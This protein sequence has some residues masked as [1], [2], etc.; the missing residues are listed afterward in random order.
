MDA[1]A[2]PL[3]LQWMFKFGA[4]PARTST[5]GSA[6]EQA[7]ELLF[8][9]VEVNGELL[10]GIFELEIAADGAMFLAQEAWA[11]ARLRPP[12]SSHRLRQGTTGFALAG[13][14]GGTYRIDRRQMRLEIEAPVAALLSSTLDLGVVQPAPAGG[15]PD[16]GVMLNYDLSATYGAAGV[17]TPGGIVELVSFSRYGKFVTSAVGAATDGRYRI[18]RLDTYWRYDIPGRMESLVIGDTVGSGG[19]WS[20]PA[21]YSGVQFARNFGLRAGFVTLPTLTLSGQAGLPSTVDV[22]V[23][24]ISRARQSVPAGPFEVPNVPLTAGAGRLNL[25]VRDL[26]GRETLVQ[27]SYYASNSL[28]APGLKDYSLEAGWLRTGYGASSE[29]GDPFTAGTLRAGISSVLTGE[30]RFELQEGRYAAGVQLAYVFGNWG[31]GRAALAVARSNLHGGSE[32]GLLYQFGAERMSSDTGVSLQYEGAT[33][34]F[35]PFAEFRDAESALQRTRQQWLAIASTRIGGIWGSGTYLHHTRWDGQR[36]ESVGAVLT[37]PV[38]RAAS[39]SANLSKRIDR[40]GGWTASVQLAVPLESGVFLGARTDRFAEGA[41][42]LTIFANSPMP[43]GAG[44]SWNVEASTHAHRLARG[45][46]R[47]HG[48]VAELALDAVSDRD[49]HVAARVDARGTVGMVGRVPFA[50]RPV[51]EGSVG[52]VQVPGMPDVPVRYRNQVI[53]TTNS[54]GMIIVPALLPWQENR[55]EIDPADLPLDVELAATAKTITPHARA[56][57]LI[58]FDVQRSISLL[59]VLHQATGSPVPLGAQVKVLPD[60]ATF[61]VGRRGKVWLSGLDRRDRRDR[62]LQITWAGE[63]CELPL[64]ELTERAVPAQIGPLTCTPEASRAM[65]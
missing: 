41:S 34:G 46:L 23:N 1:D 57:A 25:V 48:H 15:L 13:I 43:A 12:A 65:R 9:E 38:L 14:A 8:V 52:I 37:M 53:G 45:T 58:R 35:A 4:L 59:A 33:R 51:G 22:L 3:R 18:A 17:G 21:R 62:R 60:G 39:L 11:S 26:L 19:G 7:A 44:V 5:R 61:T 63:Q 16:P 24:N 27:Q 2:L 30:T 40:Q 20:R 28:L 10:P 55:F 50:T 31:A 47:V 32:R 56:G 54:K 42:G 29:Y 6:S 64:P 36:L 49:G